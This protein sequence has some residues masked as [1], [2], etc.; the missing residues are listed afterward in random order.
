[1]DGNTAKLPNVCFSHH[2]FIDIHTHI[3]PGFDDGAKNMADSLS[4]ARI[5]QSL[6][7]ATV[8]ATPHFLPGTAWAP[9][10][11]QVLAAVAD[12]NTELHRNH[13]ALNILP[14]LEIAYHR[15]M[16][17]RILANMLLALGDSGHY[18]VEPS[19]QG[20]QGELLSSIGSLL[21]QGINIILAHPERT[22][23]FQKS[24]RT[25]SRYIDQGLKIQI[26]SGSLLGNFG[27]QCKKTAEL[28][29]QENLFHFFASDAHDTAKRAPLNSVE[30]QRLRATA[31]GAKLL[32]ICKCNLEK[33]FDAA[34]SSRH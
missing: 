15:K 23:G 34:G 28:L 19:F 3:L 2:G 18:L 17:E 13:I 1:M 31:Q 10:S 8:I 12:L 24:P 5:Y 16:E 4:L 11:A 9:T 20:E 25:L 7:I 21:N 6:G 29:V 26:N 14:G 27:E 33:L 32:S 22:E 30:W